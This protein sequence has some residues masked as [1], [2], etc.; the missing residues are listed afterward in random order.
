MVMMMIMMRMMVMI[1]IIIMMIQYAKKLFSKNPLANMYNSLP[2]TR[3]E[4]LI[5]SG[6]NRIDHKPQ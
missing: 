4:R 6:L 1:I 3:L 5:R 2:K